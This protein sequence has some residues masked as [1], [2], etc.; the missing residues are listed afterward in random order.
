MSKFA[1]WFQWKPFILGL[2][3][4]LLIGA[5]IVAGCLGYRRYNN[6][7]HGHQAVFLSNGQVYFGIVQRKDGKEVQ[8][9]NI[10]YLQTDKA[11]TN[12][13]DTNQQ[14]I[15]L[16]KLGNEL[17]G[18]Q[19]IMYINRDQVLFIEDLKDDSKVVKAMQENKQ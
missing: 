10:Y 12:T 15:N 16:I 3:I 9:T 5:A 13:T 8:L 4:M 11:A 19:D 6:R 17:H 7:P 1:S 2:I 18:P 14:G